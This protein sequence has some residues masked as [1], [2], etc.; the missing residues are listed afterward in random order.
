MPY[1]YIAGGQGGDPKRAMRLLLRFLLYASLVGLI[2][3]FII[4]RGD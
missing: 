2:W 1:S 3:K 4:K